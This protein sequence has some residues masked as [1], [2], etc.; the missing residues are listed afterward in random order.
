MHR[1]AKISS[2]SW[3]TAS[4]GA[5]DSLAVDFDTFAWQHQDFLPVVAAGNFGAQDL[6]S[7]VS[8]PSTAKNCLS[9][10]TSLALIYTKSVDSKHWLQLQ[11]AYW[12]RLTESLFSMWDAWRG[13]QAICVYSLRFPFLSL[14]LPYLASNASKR[15]AFECV[16]QYVHQKLVLIGSFVAGATLT[17]SYGSYEIEQEAV[18]VDPQIFQMNVTGGKISGTDGS[19][20]IR[21]RFLPEKLSVYNKYRTYR[22]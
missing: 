6:D 9:I 3:G 13:I 16:Q 10:G 7:S 2:E 22:K 5:Y 17:G 4:Q 14:C 19:S 18:S 8:S 11:T 20:A 1:G 15:S 12:F 21:V